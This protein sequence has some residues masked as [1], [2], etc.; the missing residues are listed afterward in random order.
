MIYKYF[1]GVTFLHAD[2]PKT[3]VIGNEFDYNELPLAY[4][5]RVRTFGI[6]LH[7]DKRTSVDRHGKNK[8]GSSRVTASNILKTRMSKN[9]RVA[10]FFLNQK[11]RFCVEQAILGVCRFRGYELMAVNIRTNHFHV[12]LSAHCT[13]DRIVHAF[14]SYFTRALREEDLVTNE[15][16]LWAR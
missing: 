3:M 5:I 15:R 7:G 2:V 10:A 13:P 11:Q 14:K 16:N 4:L 6:W 9:I 1:R 8:Y 12:V